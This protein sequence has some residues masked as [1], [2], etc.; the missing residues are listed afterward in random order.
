MNTIKSHFE[1][2]TRFRNGI[3]ILAILI[4]IVMISF[5]IYLVTG[6]DPD[7]FNELSEFQIQVDSLKNVSL[8]TKEKAYKLRPFNPNFISD[9]KGYL[10]GMSA[11]ELDKLHQ[12]REQN[13]WINSVSD[14]KK[15]TGVSDSLLVVISPLFTFPD[16]IQHSKTKKTYQKNKITI[17]SYAEKE[18]LNTISTETL[19]EK[20]GVPDFIADRIVRYKESLGGFVSDLQLKDVLGLYESQRN[21]ILSLYTVKTNKNVQKININTATVKELMEVPYFDFE[22][23]LEIRDFIKENGSISD[24]EELGEIEGFYLEK[25]D[26]IAL[27]L[28]L[29]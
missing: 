10:L 8:L 17:K 14:F 22:T 12:Y 26:R 24:F 4:F 16:W 25:I 11:N 28:G 13:K 18:D 6:K 1:M 7:N 29:E 3:L 19:Q 2:H 27:Y 9:Y 15:V 20:I 23:A 21:K 5:Y